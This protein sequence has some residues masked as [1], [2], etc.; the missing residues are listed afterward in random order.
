MVYESTRETHKKVVVLTG[1]GGR[2]G[3]FL[4]ERL[5]AEPM[6]FPVFLTSNPAKLTFQGAEPHA[7]Y[8]VTLGDP[9]SVEAAFDQIHQAHGDVDVLINNAA[10]IPLPGFE[11]FVH[12]VDDQRVL[13]TYAVNVAGA[14]FC[15]KGALGRGRETG[16]TVI[17]ILAG[18]A[19]TGHVRHVEYYSSKAALHN[20]TRTLANDYPRHAF[21]N[22]MSGRIEVG[23][24][25]GQGGDNPQA[26]WD[27]IREAIFD[28]R[29]APYREV[30]FRPRMEFLR[31]LFG[32]YIKHFRSTARRD[33]TR[34]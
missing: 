27:Y 30:H 2:L 15:I 13:E 9:A 19:L 10:M 28:P 20:A 6:L 16:K 17:N 5:L 11:D 1:A 22:L 33:V 7:V 24:P 18:R 31:H 26:Y 4:A 25:E 34:R 29:P 21:R 8:P 23:G 14:L 3:R 32:H 12:K